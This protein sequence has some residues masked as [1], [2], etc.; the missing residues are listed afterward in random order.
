VRAMLVGSP[1]RWHC[2]RPRR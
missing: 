1:S 2:R